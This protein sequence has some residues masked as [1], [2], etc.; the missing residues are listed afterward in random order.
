MM[1][2]GYVIMDVALDLELIPSSIIAVAI[3]IVIKVFLFSVNYA[4]SEYLQ[5]EDDEYYY[6]VKA[7]PKVSV[8]VREKTVKKI[9]AHQNSTDKETEDE[10]N[11][12]AGIENLVDQIKPVDI[13]ESEIQK[14]IEEELKK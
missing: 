8:A 3:A 1:T 14:I 10:K 7:I 6:Y 5:F 2:F 11:D 12:V 4:R 13:E 9:N